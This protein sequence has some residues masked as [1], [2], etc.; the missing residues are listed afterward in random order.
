MTGLLKA[1]SEQQ[2][3]CC[4]LSPFPQDQGLQNYALSEAALSKE[5]LLPISLVIQLKG[6]DM[7]TDYNLIDVTG[8]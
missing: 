4:K 5:I 7:S 1:T 6:I 2:R 8:T 3:Q